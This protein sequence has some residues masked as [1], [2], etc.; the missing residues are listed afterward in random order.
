[1]YKYN[2]NDNMTK[3]LVWFSGQC[4]PGHWKDLGLNPG[5]CCSLLLKYYLGIGF[6]PGYLDNLESFSQPRNH[7]FSDYL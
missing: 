1:M 3:E 5:C 4:F 7:F 6:E 2:K